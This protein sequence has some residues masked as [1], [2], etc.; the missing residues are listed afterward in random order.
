MQ[1]ELGEPRR[2][3]SVTSVA[4]PDLLAYPY[5]YYD[6]DLLQKVREYGYGGAFTVRREATR[7]SSTRARA[8]GARSTAT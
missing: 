7:R 5:G 4:R 6:E 2:S 8:T 3:S 1:A